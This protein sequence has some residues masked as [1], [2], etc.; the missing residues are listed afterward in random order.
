MTRTVDDADTL[1][2]IYDLKDDLRRAR[3][4]LVY[5]RKRGITNKDTR[6]LE[7]RIKYL[8]NEINSKLKWISDK[9]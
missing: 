7:E 4:N 8:Q 6:R 9:E 1:N 5:W 3:R 2:R